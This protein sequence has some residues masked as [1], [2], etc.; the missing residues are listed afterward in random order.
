MIVTSLAIACSIGEYHFCCL[1]MYVCWLD[2]AHLSLSSSLRTDPDQDYGYY[3]LT[4]DAD[5][6]L[7]GS[8]RRAKNSFDRV[9][10]WPPKNLKRNFTA[11]R[12]MQD[13]RVSSVFN[14]TGS[15]G[16]PQ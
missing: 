10:Y 7:T 1:L 16:G 4:K 14:T 8:N 6:I 3:D 11:K 15:L 13:R 2:H 9:K 5:H 12:G